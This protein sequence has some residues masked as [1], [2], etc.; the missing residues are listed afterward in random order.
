MFC[1]SCWPLQCFDSCWPRRRW[2]IAWDWIVRR[3]SGLSMEILV[4]LGQARQEARDR[5]ESLRF[6][7]VRCSASTVPTCASTRLEVLV[8]YWEHTSA[9]RMSQCRIKCLNWCRQSRISSVCNIGW[10]VNFSIFTSKKHVNFKTNKIWGQGSLRF[11]NLSQE[12]IR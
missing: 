6:W 8:S 3:R 12:K 5:A 10:T 2:K 4:W 7:D 1:Y 11:L 9:L